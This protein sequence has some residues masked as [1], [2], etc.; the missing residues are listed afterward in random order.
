MVQWYRDIT[1][2][3]PSNAWAYS[4]IVIL[5]LAMVMFLLYRFG[6]LLP[7]RKTA[8]GLFI[9]FVVLFFVTMGHSFYSRNRVTHNPEAILM[10]GSETAR[11]TPDQSGTEVFVIHEGTKVRV[12]SSL[13]EWSEVEL[14][15][16]KVGW[17]LTNSFEVI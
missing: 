1:N 15:D 2:L 4:S 11:S 8:F 3:M 14:E 5:L 7:L 13:A 12:R 10:A 6:K 17:I 9:A 16:G